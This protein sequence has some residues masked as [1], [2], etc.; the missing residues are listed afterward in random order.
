MTYDLH[1]TWDSENPIGNIVQ[2]HMNL[3]EIEY[4]LEL[5]WLVSC[6]ICLYIDVRELTII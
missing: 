4:A 3:T 6:A 5:F 1:G 2:G